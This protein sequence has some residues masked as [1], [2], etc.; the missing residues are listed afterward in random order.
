MQPLLPFISIDTVILAV[1][2]I[3]TLIIGFKSGRGL[4]SIQ[5][6]SLGKR[7]FATPVLAATVVATWI[8]GSTFSQNIAKSYTDGLYYIIGNLGTVLVLLIIGLIFTPRMGEFLGKTSIAEAMGDLYGKEVRVITACAGI[9]ATTGFI[10]RQVTVS[11]IIFHYFFGIDTT[12]AVL[13]S[14]FVIITYSAY[15]GIKAVTFTDV[16]QLITF[17]VFIPILG[18]VVWHSVHNSGDVINTIKTHPNFDFSE[19]FDP[20]NPKFY[21]MLALFLGNAMPAFAPAIFQRISMSKSVI[22]AQKSFLLAALIAI[23]IKWMMS[24]IGVLLLT[25]AP[26]L[27]AKMI[28]A[29][30]VNTYSYPGMKGLILVGI[31]SMI[32]ST[33]DSHIN[34]SA[35]LFAN[36]ICIAFK[37]KG[38]RLQ[39]ILSRLFTLVVGIGAIILALIM[40]DLLKLLLLSASFYVPIVTIP[41]MA[42]IL[43][44]RT[45]K[46]AVLIGMLG[47]LVSVIVWRMFFLKTGIDSLV[48]GIIGN[49]ICLFP[50]HY[51][52][53]APGGWVG[54][55][56][57]E[58]LE[59]LKRER[60]RT[61]KMFIYSLANIRPF[62]IVK[63]SL[64]TNK[65][66]YCALG[67][68][69]LISGVTTMYNTSYAMQEQYS[70]LFHVIYNSVL[71]IST[72]F[73]TIPFWPNRFKN[74]NVIAIFWI[75]GIFYLLGLLPYIFMVVNNFDQLQLMIFMTNILIMCTL[76]RWNMVVIIL[77]SSIISG[78]YLCNSFLSTNDFYALSKHSL[79]FKIFYIALLISSS[80]AIF[81]RSKQNSEDLKDYENLALKQETQNAKIK[82]IQYSHYR[83]EFFYKLDQ[84]CIKLFQDVNLKLEKLSLPEDIE[85]FK[86]L[87]EKLK[88]GSHYLNDLISQIKENE[89]E[90]KLEN[91][92][93][94][95]FIYSLMHTLKEKNNTYSSIQY[96][97]SC[98]SISFTLDVDLVRNALKSLISSFVLDN[99]I[100]KTK[101][102]TLMYPVSFSNSLQEKR[103]GVKII[104]SFTADKN[105]SDN[106]SNNTNFL[107]LNNIIDA[108]YG[109]IRIEIVNDVFE[110]FITLPVDIN[111]IRPK[112]LNMNYASQNIFKKL[113]KN[114]EASSLSIK[115]DI[116]QKLMDLGMHPKEIIKITG[117]S[118]KEIMD[119]DD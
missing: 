106:F 24:W 111:S 10:A 58:S 56:D 66:S 88:H 15:G 115:K 62:N 118:L 112:Q 59:M 77:I 67:L 113:Q 18:L 39:L 26:G 74:I 37:K 5:D 87:S 116:T 51:I 96:H 119:F 91:T 38:E 97:S 19:I 101:D 80:L 117:I 27:K 48:P 33:A 100:I 60:V 92:R 108:H 57:K 72:I 23:T 65:I 85:E 102:T 25:I 45:S 52:T 43:G 79:Q 71:T 114:I 75:I 104:L 94:D 76:L 99:L 9:L 63:Q 41:F 109:D 49:V 81:S 11:S 14:S 36:D 89:I 55:K 12:Y 29:H 22:Q 110:L 68:Y 98:K 16:M 28:L 8:S 82:L 95:D 7:N 46:K 70:F 61:I 86:I 50:A 17:S 42:A 103:E 83:E 93:I 64:P 35:V 105:L 32:M 6:Y 54:I 53:K 20:H 73:I 34:A 3:T 13:L 30:V 47:G 107:Y 69:S 1:F 4:S 78:Y 90:L 31:M 40:D 2:I 44:F 21:G 84:D